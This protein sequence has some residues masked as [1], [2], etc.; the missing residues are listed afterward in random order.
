MKPCSFSPQ[1][2]LDTINSFLDLGYHI[3]PVSDY[4]QNKIYNKQILLRH[5]VDF[6]LDYA[7]D[8]ALLEKD[9]CVQA[10]YYIQVRSDLYNALSTE[11]SRTISE[12]HNAGHEIGLH[13]DSRS[14]KGCIDFEILSQLARQDVIQWSKHLY[15]ITPDPTPIPDYGNND[16]PLKNG[17]QYIADSAMTW[18]NGCFC[19]CKQ[20]KIQILIHPE[21]WMTRPSGEANRWEVLEILEEAARQQTAAAFM[22]FREVLKQRELEVVE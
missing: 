9:I 6:N 20:D 21:W 11:G 17:Y 22:D 2:Y 3:G 15:T 12:I 4:F 8:M 1:H 14:Y 5:D 18:R 7:L 10:T 13:I 16:I 19:E